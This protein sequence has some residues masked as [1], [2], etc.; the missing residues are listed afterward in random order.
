M[1]PSSPF[2]R[3]IDGQDFGDQ[4]PSGSGTFQIVGSGFGLADTVGG[5]GDIMPPLSAYGLKILRPPS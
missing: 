3:V 1:N 5:F 4:F 2:W